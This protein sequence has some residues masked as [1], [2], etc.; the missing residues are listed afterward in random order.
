MLLA[1][2]HP[3]AVVFLLPQAAVVVLRFVAALVSLHST[4]SCRCVLADRA[5]PAAG[6]YL[7]PQAAVVCLRFVASLLV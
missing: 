4:L 3:D 6:V 1:C 2:G 5:R 7:L